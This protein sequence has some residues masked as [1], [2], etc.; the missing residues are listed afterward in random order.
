MFTVNQIIAH[1]VGDYLLQSNWMA[2]E[3]I[4]KFWVAL[5][6][7]LFYSLP[8]FLITQSTSALMVIIV[9]HAV[10]DRW[11]LAKYVGW[12]KNQIGPPNYWYHFKKAN[13]QGYPKN[14]PEWL[15]NFLLFVTDNTMH[16]IINALA[17]YYL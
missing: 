12:A 3:K 14:T 6:H 13:S 15:S 1:L 8:F 7:G 11:R 5:V 4:S 17:I 10:I 16:I 2:H 9:N